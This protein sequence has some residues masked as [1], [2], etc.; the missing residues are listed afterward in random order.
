ME[1]RAMSASRDGKGTLV[2]GTRLR[3]FQDLMR[4]RVENI[5]LVS[6]LYDS[7][8]LA[9][10]G[11]LNELIL[12][13]FLHLNLLHTPGLTHVSSGQRRWSWPAT[14]SAST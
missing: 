2:H 4:R 7:F 1:R 5:L 3:G 12:S 13:E 8:I 10:D 9:E 14:P 6:S 11:Q